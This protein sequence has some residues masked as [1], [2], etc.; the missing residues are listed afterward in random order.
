MV[1]AVINTAPIDYGQI[2]ANAFERLGYRIDGDEIITPAGV[3][4]PAETMAKSTES[5]AEMDA[6]PS[7]CISL[8]ELMAEFDGQ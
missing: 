4:L 5:F 2:L 7:S 3:V 1:D 6:D 8:D